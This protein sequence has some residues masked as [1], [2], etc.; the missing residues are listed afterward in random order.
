MI[1][2]REED[3]MRRGLMVFGI[4]AL[5]AWSP[6][7]A[8]AGW[9]TNS[10]VY[11]YRPVPALWNYGK[12]LAVCAFDKTVIFVAEVVGNMNAN[13]TTL[14]PILPDPVPQPDPMPDAS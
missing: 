11:L 5:L 14:K 8:E 4:V 9:I 10:L 1:D 12:G 13:P 3:H 7:H 2:I 6:D